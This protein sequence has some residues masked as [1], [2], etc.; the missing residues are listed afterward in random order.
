MQSEEE[1]VEILTTNCQLFQCQLNRTQPFLQLRYEL[2]SGLGLLGS[3]ARHLL[4]IYHA[5]SK[6]GIQCLEIR[7]WRPVVCAPTF[8][9]IGGNLWR[10][11]I[12]MDFATLKY[13][14]I[15]ERLPLRDWLD[16]LLGDWEDDEYRHGWMSYEDCKWQHEVW[17]SAKRRWTY[18]GWVPE[19]STWHHR[20]WD[21]EWK[22]WTYE[23]PG[24]VWNS[25]Q[26]RCSS[27]TS[28]TDMMRNFLF[29]QELQDELIMSMYHKF[30]SWPCPSET[31]RIGRHW[32]SWYP[33]GIYQ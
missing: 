24:K 7:S 6:V 28:A 8:T 25:V 23:D 32:D 33:A 26:Q 4:E 20:V 27:L 21:S 14:S 30:K 19:D 11:H 31:G 1:T 5:G 17:D 10:V 15:L 29:L 18:D 3:W 9:P 22:R 2:E 16:P 12:H 13:M